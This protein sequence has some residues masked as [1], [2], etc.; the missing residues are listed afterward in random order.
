MD[1]RKRSE[2]PDAAGQGPLPELHVFPAPPHE[3][4]VHAAN[5]LESF[6]GDGQAAAAGCVF[7][8]EF[9]VCGQ[10]RLSGGNFLREI[11]DEP[12]QIDDLM[13]LPDQFPR[14][15]R[16]SI[17]NQQIV[18]VEDQHSAARQ[19]GPRIERART[20]IGRCRIADRIVRVSD[21]TR[22]TVADLGRGILLDHDAFGSDPLLGRNG[23]QH[24]QQLRKSFR[25]P[26]ADDE[27][28]SGRRAV[29]SGR[30]RRLRQANGTIA[31]GGGQQLPPA[32]GK[33][34]AQMEGAGEF[35]IASR[36]PALRVE[37]QPVAP[38]A[39]A[40]P[41][42]RSAQGPQEARDVEQQRA[43][44]LPERMALHAAPPSPSSSARNVRATAARE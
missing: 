39:V 22:K 11:E 13:A 44:L 6:T 29:R 15:L 14:L 5:G 38:V 33:H 35:P 23:L 16:I 19:G 41:A 4:F 2:I 18:V 31:Q 28:D 17:R 25:P 8:H 1:Q 37:P 30:G 9:H 21:P 20:G 12:L 32:R 40:H 10:R 27:A 43:G 36:A 42:A 3:G 24:Q 26:V 34:V 7:Q